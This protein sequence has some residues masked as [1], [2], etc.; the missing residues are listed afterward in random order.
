MLCSIINTD[1]AIPSS[2][3]Q[4]GTATGIFELTATD[5]LIDADMSSTHSHVPESLY[6]RLLKAQ[7][8]VKIK[9]SELVFA[10]LVVAQ[11]EVEESRDKLTR[12]IQTEKS[13]A[14]R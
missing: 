11:I 9:K 3:Q 1:E 13:V 4:T 8:T 12:A 2:A 14:L 10:T 7:L 5:E 6:V